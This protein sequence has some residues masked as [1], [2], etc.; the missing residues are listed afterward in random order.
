M[1]VFADEWN[2]FTGGAVS[3]RHPEGQFLQGL[4]MPVVFVPASPVKQYVP[5][6]SW[7]RQL[8]CL[9]AGECRQ[10]SGS[11]RFVLGVLYISLAVGLQLVDLR[12]SHCS[13]DL[14]PLHL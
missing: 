6:I 7:W 5:R 4:R 11:V 1:C 3:D 14:C 13:V 9:S 8:G 10:E 2:F 12:G